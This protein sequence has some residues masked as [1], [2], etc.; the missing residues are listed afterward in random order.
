MARRKA[1]LDL[2]LFPF[3]SVLC[4]IIA[5]MV[6]F[7]IVTISTRVINRESEALTAESGDSGEAANSDS[8]VV[9]DGIDAATY[10]QLERQIKSLEAA[11]EQRRAARAEI[12]LKLRDVAALIAAKEFELQQARAIDRPKTNVRIGEPSPLRIIPAPSPDGIERTA[13]FI[14]VSSS[15]YIVHPEKTSFAIDPKKKGPATDV[16]V[17][18]GLKKVLADLAKNANSKYP[19]FLIRTDGADAFKAV[20]SHV[21]MMHPSLRTGWEPFSREYLL[22]TSSK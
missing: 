16:E 11:L 19:L 13:V 4:G 15:G 9:D 22:D 17:P 21:R 1:K 3:L 12:R 10:E 18:D 20:R 5:V 2:T 6:L 8:A 7:M 14:E